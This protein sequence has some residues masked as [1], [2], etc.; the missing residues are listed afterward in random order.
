MYKISSVSLL[1]IKKKK[2]SAQNPFSQPYYK[3]DSKPSKVV[4]VEFHNWPTADTWKQKPEK[5]VV[6][7]R[8]MAI[9]F[10]LCSSA[11]AYKQNPFQIKNPIFFHLPICL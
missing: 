9:R 2:K 6:E 11:Y 1:P 10:I 7:R 5:A 3:H 8:H 4:V